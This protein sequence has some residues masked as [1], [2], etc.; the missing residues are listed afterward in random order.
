[1]SPVRVTFR[2]TVS[3]ARG[4]YTSVFAMAGFLSAAAALFALNIE[5]AE[6]LRVNLVP[7]WTVSAAAPLPFLAAILGMDVWSEEIR[8]SRIDL[9]LTSP[10]R[11]RDLVVGKFLGIWVL[12][13]AGVLLFLAST[14]ASLA[15]FAPRLAEGLSFASFLPGVFALALQGALWCA[16]TVAA[17]SFFRYPA[18]AAAV[19][20]AILSAIPRGAFLALKAWSGEGSASFGEMPLDAHA[21]DLSSGF[22][23]T[24]TLAAYVLFTLAA[25]FISSKKIASLRLSGRGARGL[26]ASTFFA[27]ALS[28]AAALLAVRLAVRLDL[29]LDLPSSG[30]EERLT[31]RTK[32]VLAESQGSMMITAF[33]GRKDARFREVGR[34][35]RSLESEAESQC[36][37]KLDIRYV[38]PVLDT[39]AALRLARANVPAGSLVFEREGEVVG[40]L[41]L[42]GGWGERACVSMIE[43]AAHPMRKD[44]VYWTTGHGEADFESY[45]FDGLSTIARDLSLDG[46]LSRKIDLSSSGETIADDCALVVIAA[47]VSE[48]SSAELSRLRTYL[49]GSD[50]RNEGGRLLVLVNTA[51]EGG[52]ATLL[53]EW[54]IRLV[55]GPPADGRTLSGTDVI[56]AD[57][58]ANPAT[59]PLAGQRIVLE[60]PVAFKRS[61]AAGGGGVDRKDFSE[62]VSAGSACVAALVESGG[63]GSDIALR[64]TRIAAVGDVAFVQNGFLEKMGN[65]NR[66]FFLNVVKFLSGRD[67]FTGADTESGRL[68]TGLDRSAKGRFSA[69]SAVLFPGGFL[70][71]ASLAV[72]FR[73][74]RK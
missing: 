64:P 36:G 40:H 10:V 69:V 54:G 56:A 43:R 12:T 19:S 31:E 25:L 28:V 42:D 50:G 60:S 32:S 55:K 51:R 72:A 37:L 6:G 4:L 8:T 66:D 67:A 17:S 52:I 58:S 16:V 23:S 45:A 61:A 49:D 1:M 47:P 30:S 14:L 44:S 5:S 29:T 74:R 59:A 34:F 68:V 63:T 21:Y 2:R 39:G 53:S 20:I 73:R 48:F 70:I 41:P 38:D 26:R 27:V 3:L 24:G 7:L 11:E 62:L 18:A 35:L 13:V 33:L 9:L 57:F 65:A 15:I 71:L 22:V 46:Y